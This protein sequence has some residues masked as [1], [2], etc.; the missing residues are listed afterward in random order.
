MR[1]SKP[2]SALVSAAEKDGTFKAELSGEHVYYTN[3]RNISA[4]RFDFELNKKT[5]VMQVKIQP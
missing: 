5:G 2:M 1:I 4:F 3:S